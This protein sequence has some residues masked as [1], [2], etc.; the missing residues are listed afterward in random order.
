MPD[1]EVSAPAKVNFGLQVVG[2]RA[3]GYHL[4]ETIFQEVDFCD[5]LY[6]TKK[7]EG[8]TIECH[9]PQ[10]PSDERNLC[11]KAYN[12]LQ[13]Y[14]SSLPSVHI[15]IE[16]QIPVGAGLGGGSSDAA[17]TLLAL[18]ENYKLDIPAEK[19]LEIACELGADVPFFLH[20][21]TAFAR[22][23]GE[24]LEMIHP[25]TDNYIL[26]SVPDI[27]ISTAWAYENVKYTLTSDSLENKLK[28]F[29]EIDGDLQRFQ[30]IFESLVIRKYSKIDEI[31]DQMAHF[32]A[33]YVSVSG[34][35]SAVFGVYPEKAIAEEAL[36]H[37]S[38]NA[39][40]VLT[41]PVRREVPRIARIPGAV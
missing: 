21:G 19:L 3:D 39:F 25:L 41:Q 7:G 29:F 27:H 34:S 23:I 20:G 16:K 2:K 12:Y 15:K 36:I 18:C 32:H 4:I 35:G 24:Q 14:Y 9:H 37:L 10:V 33:E 5:T 28:G 26:I 30:N 1:F 11:W 22:G 17:A 8:C 31:K 6:F 13:Q 38:Q 40:S